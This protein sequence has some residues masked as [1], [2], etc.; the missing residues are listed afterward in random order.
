MPQYEKVLIVVFGR[1]EEKWLELSSWYLIGHWDTIKIK[2]D[3]DQRSILCVVGY[4]LFREKNNC[5]IWIFIIAS[6]MVKSLHAEA[7]FWNVPDSFGHNSPLLTAGFSFLAGCLTAFS[8]C[9]YPLIPITLSVMGARVYQSRLHGFLVALTYVLGMTMIY[10]TLG[11][12]FASFGMI[13]GSFMQHPLML[14]TLAAFLF[15]MGLSSWGLFSIMLPERISTK[16]AHVGGQGFKGALFMGVVSGFLAAPCTGPVLASI[17][18]LIATRQNPIF[19]ALLMVCFSFGLGL[20]FLL[21]GTFSQA[22]IRLPKAGAF[23]VIVKRILGVSMMGMAIYFAVMAIGELN[24]HAPIQK[25]EV[26]INHATTDEELFE[27]MLLLAKNQGH[28]VMIDF[29]A[30]WCV[31]CHQLEEITFVEP[32]V[33]ATLA[34]FVGIKIDA[35]KTSL[36]LERLMQ[37][38]T[39]VGLPTIVF[40]GK[41][42]QEVR[43]ARVVGF[44]PPANF[45]E[46]LKQVQNHN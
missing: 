14:F 25:D 27:R 31:A 43:E 32:S 15:C 10:A 35:T 19:G 26:V 34:P 29:Y 2:S 21:L 13:L 28:A 12:I 46:R 16:L 45:L 5:T 7:G 17:L 9:I 40:I 18:T 30:D 4:M 37:R 39:V 33:A 22:L 11:G 36:Y 42:G 6:V 23:L 38:F 3:R 1:M 41:N 24:Q 8:P 20:P 44:M